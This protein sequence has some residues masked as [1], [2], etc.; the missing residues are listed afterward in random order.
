MSEKISR[1]ALF[2]LPRARE[3][4][5][6]TE[7]E[8][9][10]FSLGDFYAKRAPRATSASIPRFS[11][12]APDAPLETTSVGVTRAALPPWELRREARAGGAPKLG[13]LVMVVR[14]AC[15]AWGGTSCW[16]CSERCP[17]E[18]AITLD[19]GRPT[20]DVTRCDGCGECVAACPAPTNALKLAEH[21]TGM[22]AAP[23]TGEA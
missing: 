2:T 21:A 6:T 20:I 18:G 3:A 15:L 19:A 1:R 10:P 12:R 14:S 11:V 5:R 8:G 9:T 16:T 7:P 17:V 23:A 22:A 4:Q 13:G